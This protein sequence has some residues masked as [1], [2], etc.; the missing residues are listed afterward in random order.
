MNIPTALQRLHQ[1][2]I[3]YYSCYADMMGSVAGGVILSQ[4]LFHYGKYGRRFYKTDKEILAETHATIRELREAKVKLKTLPF[5]TISI[6]GLPATTWYEVQEDQ[7]WEA[8]SVQPS[9]NDGVQTGK[10]DGVQT[11]ENDGVQPVYIDTRDSESTTEST[12]E[13]RQDPPLAPPR[14]K[15]PR[16]K[17]PPSPEA[18]EVLAYLCTQTGRAFQFCTQIDTLLRT[19][20]SVEDCKLVIDFGVAV[21]Q[22]EWGDK[23]ER[24][25]DNV[26]PFRPLNFDR[27]HARALQ[28]H[29]TPTT[30]QNGYIDSLS[31]ERILPR[32][33]VL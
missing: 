15:H 17:A 14:G 12:T 1:S 26:T 5:L 32:K 13:T 11:S 9:S 23:Y 22:Q 29:K 28:W 21:L 3:A 30:S 4:L 8:L 33:M 2:P 10:N 7:L 6:E 24:Y 27:Y 16:K 19:G 31:G 25:F 20:V 18:R